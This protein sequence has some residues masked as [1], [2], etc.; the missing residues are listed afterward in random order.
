MKRKIPYSFI[1]ALLVL[2]LAGCAGKQAP[3]S[4]VTRNGF[5]FDTFVQITLYDTDDETILDGCMELANRYENM[6]S[7]TKEGSDIWNINH[8]GGKSVAVSEETANLIRIALSY[9]ARTKGI[10]DPAIGTVSSLWNFSTEPKGPVPDASEIENALQ[11]VGYEKVRVEGNTVTVSDPALQIDL[12]AIAKGFIADR[13]REYLEERGVH[14]ALI[15]LGG[16]VLAIGEKPDGSPFQIGIQTPFSGQGQIFAS[17]PLRGQSLVSSGNYE[18][19]FEEN[20]VLYHHILDPATGYPADSGVLGVTILA[21]DSVDADALSTICFLLGTEKGLDL[22][23]HTE[24]AEALF[25]TGT[26]KDIAGYRT[27]ASSGFPSAGKP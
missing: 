13:F 12:G 8:A 27:V 3:A 26:P 19:F 16:N 15:N 2:L 7:R 6:L 14:S 21:D 1:C 17:V 20:G 23:E 25:I 5:F 22:I 9:S 11:H 10:F 18:R 4:P 24:G